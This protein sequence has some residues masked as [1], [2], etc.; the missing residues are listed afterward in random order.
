MSEAENGL[1][2]R[3]RR[4]VAEVIVNIL[5]RVIRLLVHDRTASNF[6][7][8]RARANIDTGNWRLAIAAANLA[9]H[10]DERSHYGYVML[11]YARAKQGALGDALTVLVRGSQAAIESEPFVEYLEYVGDLLLNQERF[12]CAEIAY[13]R[14]YMLTR[15]HTNSATMSN[16]ARSIAKQ[17]R[18]REAYELLTSA[19]D[20]Y[21]SNTDFLLVLGSIEVELGHFDDAL[22]HLEAARNGSMANAEIEYYLAYAYASARQW[23]NGLKAADRAVRL[24]LE[25]RYRRNLVDAGLNQ[26]CA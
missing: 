11:G 17:Q 18:P 9:I 16:L 10:L 19:P 23:E 21:K 7:A 1:I 20:D 24:G 6:F 3:V 2:P 22:R 14:A 5:E 4:L 15:G 12:Q 26:P 13:S 25:E 8:Q